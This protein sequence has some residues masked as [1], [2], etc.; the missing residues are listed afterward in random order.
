VE[1]IPRF[2]SATKLIMKWTLI[3]WSVSFKLLFETSMWFR[4]CFLCLLSPLNYWL[5]SYSR[6]KLSRNSTKQFLHALYKHLDDKFLE[7]LILN[8]CSEKMS[9]SIL[10]TG[11]RM[12]SALVDIAVQPDPFESSINIWTS[13]GDVIQTVPSLRSVLFCSIDWDEFKFS[14]IAISLQSSLVSK[15]SFMCCTMDKRACT[16]LKSIFETSHVCAVYFL[17]WPH[18]LWN[19]IV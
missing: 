9:I 14:P 12:H 11:L 7:T 5:C 17:T 10:L 18:L 16:M 3:E 13:L 19:L 15:I 8:E 2:L 1:R 4:L 6:A